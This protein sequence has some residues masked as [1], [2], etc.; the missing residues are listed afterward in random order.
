MVLEVVL[1]KETVTNIC[2]FSLFSGKPFVLLKRIFIQCCF[3]RCTCTIGKAGGSWGLMACPEQGDAVSC[4]LCPHHRDCRRACTP[5]LC[6]PLIINPPLWM[7]DPSCQLCNEGCTLW[8]TSRAG[9]LAAVKPVTS[10]VRFS[11]ENK[12]YKT[13]IYFLPHVLSNLLCSSAVAFP[14]Q[15]AHLRSNGKDWWRRTFQ[16]ALV[17]M[18]RALPG[19]EEYWESMEDHEQDRSRTSRKGRHKRP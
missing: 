10:E 9:Q 5:P 7:P 18:S 3:L 1:A 14:R 4:P 13:S 11:L 6:V 8:R 2:S 19:Q 15:T 16:S 12:S 17:S